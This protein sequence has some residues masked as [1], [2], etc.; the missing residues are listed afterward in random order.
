MQH[1]DATDPGRACMTQHRQ[2]LAQIVQIKALM[3]RSQW[4]GTGPQ[5]HQP[6]RFLLPKNLGTQATLPG[7]QYL[8]PRLEVMYIMLLFIYA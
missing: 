5:L 8:E 6:L 4:M 2:V 1:G 3:M 7:S